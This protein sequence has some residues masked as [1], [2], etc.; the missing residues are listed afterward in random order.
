MYNSFIEILDGKYSVVFTSKDTDSSSSDSSTES[1]YNS[2]KFV[3][4]VVT[5]GLKPINNIFIV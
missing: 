5:Q 4:H 2:I 1:K 3:I